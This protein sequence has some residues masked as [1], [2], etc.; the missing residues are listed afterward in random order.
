M[1]HSITFQI[2]EEQSGLTL[3]MKG[4][5]LYSIL[6]DLDNFLRREIKYG[7]HPEPVDEV[8]Q[9]CRNK[10]YELLNQREI[11]LWGLVT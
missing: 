6:L 4:E 5:D 10:L 2:P 7:D 9:K 11:D 3:A 8:Y 1:Q